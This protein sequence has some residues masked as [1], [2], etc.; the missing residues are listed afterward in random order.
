MMMIKD[1]AAAKTNNR[2]ERSGNLRI[3]SGKMDKHDHKKMQKEYQR[4]VRKR[5]T[6]SSTFHKSCHTLSEKS[7]EVFL[8]ATE[9]LYPDN[10]FRLFWDLFLMLLILYELLMVPLRLSFDFT[11]PRAMQ[12]WEI[13]LNVMFICD[14][15]INFNTG[16]YSKGLLVMERR[17]I[18]INYLKGWFWID[19]IASFPY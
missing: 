2:Q 8:K 6:F 18:V 19:L 1:L 10:R 7:K 12:I 5:T 11:E 15:F 13:I 3:K 9:V 14:I 17:R 16:Y 4:F